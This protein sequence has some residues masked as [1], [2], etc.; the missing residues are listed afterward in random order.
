MYQSALSTDEQLQAEYISICGEKGV[1][2]IVDTIL[3]GVLWLE[4]EEYIHVRERLRL[5][6]KNALTE[7]RLDELDIAEIAAQCVSNPTFEQW[8]E[9][10]EERV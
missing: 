2:T 1:D 3:D 9:D 4:G 5:A 6:M 8:I 10:G 7:A